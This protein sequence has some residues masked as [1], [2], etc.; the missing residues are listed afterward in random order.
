MKTVKEARNEDSATRGNWKTERERES[1]KYKRETNTS[2][3]VCMLCTHTH[4]HTHTQTCIIHVHVCIDIMMCMYACKNVRTY[5][6]MCELVQDILSPVRENGVG[7]TL[8]QSVQKQDS[9]CVFLHEFRAQGTH[10]KEL[11][12]VIQR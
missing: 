6:Y 12:V 9:V 2:Y 5:V 7:G 8:H 1:T 10:T 11:A 4:T 3:N